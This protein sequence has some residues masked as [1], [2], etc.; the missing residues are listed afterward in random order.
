MLPPPADRPKLAAVLTQLGSAVEELLLAGLTTAS[1]ATRQTVSAAMQEAARFR[2]LRLGSTLRAV[3]EEMARF[4]SH[5]P[6][7]SRRRLTFFLSRA[8]LLS[9]GLGHALQTTNEKEYDRLTWSPPTQPLPKVEVVCLGVVKKVAAGAVVFD[10]RLRAIAD[11][12]PVKVGQKLAWSVVFPVKPGVE[13]PPEG[14]LHLPQKQKFNTSIVLELKRITIAN[15]QVSFDES[16]SGRI[17]LTDQSTVALGEK[18]ADWEKFLN[19]S[20]ESAVERI[21]KNSPGPL[22]ID[23]ELQEEVAVREYAIGAAAPGETPGMTVYPIIAGGLE[24]SATIAVDG[25][26]KALKKNLVELSKQKKDRPPLYGLMHY[27]QCKLVFQ[28][29]TVFRPVPDYI[30]ISKDNIDKAALLK[31]LKFT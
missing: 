9:R 26:G 22:D 23:T 5:D 31:A 11:A 24:L 30:T 7:F 17:S 20:P 2:L 29:L 8:W 14:F 27:E 16:G 10:F 13:I 28:P 19:W 1:E 15:A 3:M 4:T 21:R 12:A 25:E 6:L 18:F